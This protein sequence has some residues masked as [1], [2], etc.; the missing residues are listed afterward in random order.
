MSSKEG[1]DRMSPG[2]RAPTSPGTSGGERMGL[3]PVARVHPV[4]LLLAGRLVSGI[5]DSIFELAMYWLVYAATHSRAAVGFLGVA[6][7]LG[8]LVSLATGVWADR[9]DARRTL[10]LTDL[11]RA[12]LVLGILLLAQ[13]SHGA[14][15]LGFWLI[16]AFL[17]TAMGSLFRTARSAL[18]VQEVPDEIR[19]T[20]NGLMQSTSALA[21]LGGMGLGG[22]LIAYAGAIAALGSDAIAFTLSGL[23]L[24]LL[25]VQRAASGPEGQGR[26]RAGGWLSSFREGQATLWASPVLRRA[27]LLALILNFG[28]TA[29]EVLLAAWVKGVLHAPSTVYGLLGASV[30]FGALLSGVLFQPVL[31]RTS[32]SLALLGSVAAMG[33]SVSLFS[34]LPS[35]LGDVPCLL[36][37]GL[38][39]GLA[40][41][42]LTTLLQARVPKPQMGR[43]AGTTQALSAAANPMGAALAGGVLA[44]IPIGDVFLGAGLLM[45]FAP[46]V[47]IGRGPLQADG[48]ASVP[49]SG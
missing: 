24:I 20:A 45:L 40:S 9:L 44:G 25:R 17:L 5:G 49:L 11:I 23:S 43:V 34:R 36:V 19:P 1:P 33:L 12:L 3:L 7:G 16:G 42:A 15:P 14:V 4:G 21:Q 41:S 18:W 26:S 10:I 32:L 27:I 46:L 22:T 31:R 39:S 29:L 38:G 30:L 8:Y 28:G 47:W 35:A 13:E 6:G 2:P 48:A 37:F